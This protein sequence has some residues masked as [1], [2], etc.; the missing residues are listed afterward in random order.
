[1]PQVPHNKKPNKPLSDTQLKVLLRTRSTE[2]VQAFPDCSDKFLR[3]EIKR[4]RA[5][6]PEL[7]RAGGGFATHQKP[8]TTDQLRT[9][10]HTK[11]SERTKVFPGYTFDFLTAELRRARTEV[12][13]DQ[14]IKIDAEKAR[15]RAKESEAQRMI[16][17]Q[18]IEIDRLTSELE[19]VSGW[20]KAERFAFQIKTKKKTRSVGVPVAVASDW[21]CEEE[22]TLEKSAGLNRYNLK[23]FQKSAKLFYEN[24]LN[25]IDMLRAR[26]E[27]DTLILPMIGDLMSGAI[28]D[29]LK[30]G[31]LLGPM[32]AAILAQ[33]TAATGYDYLLKN[34]DLKIISPW[35]IGNHE[36][37]THKP[38]SSLTAHANST[39]WLMSHG[40]QREFRNEPRIQI[41]RPRAY[42]AY[43]DVL[44]WKLR[45]HH[46]DK[47]K[48]NK[49]VGGITIGTNKMIN[50]W[51]KARWADLDVFGHH[52]TLLFGANFVSN[53][54]MIGY[55]PYSIDGGYD[56]QPPQQAFFLVTKRAPMATRAPIF[57]R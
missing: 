42:H 4:A 20:P 24:T 18:Q 5:R 46:G 38:R 23:I 56:Y 15:V 1:M 21:H 35:C 36:R 7:I 33:D 2:R 44:G 51:N 39:S 57:V 3:Q 12:P 32:D 31:C 54:S 8:L 22:V 34:S 26:S 53:G 45:F 17:A 52:H 9:L 19:I 27:I 11:K 29:D 49:G 13:I 37:L 48:Y 25:L 16:K 43:L 47:I 50:A 55:S 41:L 30:E 28:H 6:F 40:I 10:L 14:Q